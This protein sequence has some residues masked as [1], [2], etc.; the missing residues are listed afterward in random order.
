[1]K[2]ILLAAGY[3]TRLHPLTADRPKMLLPVG[4]RPILDWIADKVDEVDEVEELHVV[5]NGRFADALG[6]WASGRRG[7]LAPVV[8]DDG[9]TSN[10]DRLGALGDIQFVLEQAQ[11]EDDD[12][13]V[14][15]GD[16]LFEFGLTDYVADWRRKGI[17]SAVA[18]YDCGSLE[19][20]SQYGVVATDDEGRVVEFVEKPPEPPT[21]LVATASYLYHR[22]HLPL[23]GRYL[24]DGNSPDAPGNF[25]AWL[26]PRE[27]VYGYRFAGAWFDIGDHD[28]LLVADN[29]LRR[30]LGLPER[31]EYVLESAHI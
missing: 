1:M 29:R 17:A 26:Y 5:S 14:V 30:R 7:R 8:H 27:P 16:N 23:L 25:I 2:A 12:L 3:A 24:A 31:D 19:L 4:G 9:T 21:T 20:A 18:L 10:D 28:Q 13:L 6:G 11:I 22:E 15:A